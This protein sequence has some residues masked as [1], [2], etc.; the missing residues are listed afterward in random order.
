MEPA[1]PQEINQHI[2]ALAKLFPFRHTNRC[3]VSLNLLTVLVDH[4]TET[5]IDTETVLEHDTVT[6]TLLAPLSCVGAGVCV[7]LVVIV[8]LASPGS[9]LLANPDGSPLRRKPIKQPGSSRTSLLGAERSLVV[10]VAAKA[11]FR[12]MKIPMKAEQVSSC[13]MHSSM[14][15]SVCFSKCQ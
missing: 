12:Q 9:V 11:H 6:E 7:I 2:A 5:V 8:T 14:C 1:A 15:C 4:D 10:N 13:Q 3:L